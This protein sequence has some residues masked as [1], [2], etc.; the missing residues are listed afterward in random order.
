MA[1]DSSD[2]NQRNARSAPTKNAKLNPNNEPGV[3]GGS[4]TQQFIL[5]VALIVFIVVIGLIGYM[6]TYGM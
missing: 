5:A 3:E 4:E 6:L 1:S 2:P